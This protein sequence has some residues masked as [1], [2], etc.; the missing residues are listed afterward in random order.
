MKS[1]AV[2]KLS[3]QV[4][5]SNMTAIVTCTPS[6]KYPGLFI[7]YGN[8]PLPE[9]ADCLAAL[10]ACER[11]K[12]YLID[13][14]TSLIDFAFGW[15]NM[16]PALTLQHY[17]LESL[18]LFRIQT[19]ANCHVILSSL[20][21]T[22]FPSAWR[23]TIR[24]LMHD[25]GMDEHKAGSTVQLN[26][27]LDWIY[28]VEEELRNKIEAQAKLPASPTRRTQLEL[29]LDHMATIFSPD[30]PGAIARSLELLDKAD[31][32]LSNVMYGNSLIKFQPSE[33]QVIAA[34]RS[35]LQT[36]ASQVRTFKKKL[37]DSTDS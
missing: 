11:A 37:E 23:D 22:A 2:V 6:A 36:K 9:F 13:G 8:R 35:T 18:S 4:G 29:A 5:E 12:K 27:Q 10:D 7:P 26:L 14:V 3:N 1:V 28:L 33:V 16:E 25:C 19:G 21:A 15:Q 17:F 20:Q 31:I 32:A 34:V 24:V 30:D